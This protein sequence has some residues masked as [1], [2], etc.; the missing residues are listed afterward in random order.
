MYKSNT[1]SILKHLDF[2]IFDILVFIFAYTLTY[3]AIRQGTLTNL[4]GDTLYMGKLAVLIIAHFA[5]VIIANSYKSILHRGYGVELMKVIT[6]VSL[7]VGAVLIYSFMVKDASRLS[8]LFFGMFY[9][10]SIGLI[11]IERVL[12]K[13]HLLVKYSKDDSRRVLIAGYKEDIEQI[14]VKFSNRRFLAFK[15]SGI[16]LQQGNDE[17]INGI[18]VIARDTESAVRYL[19]NNVV[20]SVIFISSFDKPLMTDLIEKCE[21]AGMTIHVAYP[22][23]DT[24]IGEQTVEKVGG[25]P[26][27]T[28]SIKLVHDRDIIAKRIIDIL[29]GIVGSLLTLFVLIFIA[30]ILYINDPGPIFFKQKR[31][32][33]DGRIFGMYK[34][35]SMYQDAEERKAALMEKNEMQGF[36]FKMEDDPRIIGSGE[37]GKKHGIGWFIRTTSLDELP[38]FF[39]VLKGDMSV[40]G[41]RPPTLDEWNQYEL[42][43]RARMRIKP[44]ITGLW[45]VSGRNEITDFEEVVK[46]DKQYIQNWSVFQD[47]KIILKTV[48]VVLKRKGSK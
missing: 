13:S 23:M 37:D 20:D 19:E 26:V 24:L 2:M 39:N 1:H 15:I 25:V 46:L 43:H 16:I 36:M 33:M 11:Y 40:V 29:G 7:V 38:Q 34:I 6:H 35:R 48:Y 30:P 47:I 8:R 27:I 14:L 22:Q 10:Y 21:I 44:G 9:L 12:W 45:Q 5:V 41:T 28:S 4:L 42:H 31:V 17:E 32:G 3:T 18:P